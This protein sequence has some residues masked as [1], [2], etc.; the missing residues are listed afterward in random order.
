MQL[1]PT[2]EIIGGQCVNLRHTPKATPEIFDLSPI[3]AAKQFQDE[4]ATYLQVTDLDAAFGHGSDNTAVIERLIA[5]VDIPV[6]VAGGIHSMSIADQWINAGA[7]RLIIGSAAVLNRHVVEQLIVKY[8]EKIVVSL[9]VKAGHVVTNGWE[10]T[11]QF[12]ASE[13]AKYYENLGVAAIIYTDID[14]YHAGTELSLANVTELAS[15]VSCPVIASGVALS[16]D[17]IAYL[18]QLPKIYGAVVGWALFN[19]VFTLPEALAI[20]NQPF[21][22]AKF[23]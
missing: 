20:A 18:R 7:D 19:H 4:G 8:P 17:D 6:Q 10:R 5:T 13:L 23:I 3:D 12:T 2:I 9:D 22:R 11:S 21:V 15:Q 16:L 1:Y 14:H